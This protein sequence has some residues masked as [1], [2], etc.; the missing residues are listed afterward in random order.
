MPTWVVQGTGD[1]I[2]PEEFARSLVE[3]LRELGAKQ[4]PSFDT[5]VSNKTRSF[6]KTGSGHTLE[7]LTKRGIFNLFN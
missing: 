3:G 7:K 4:T 5:S 6:D 1:E 2:C